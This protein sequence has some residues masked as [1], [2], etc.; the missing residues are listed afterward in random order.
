MS[1]TPW[2]ARAVVPVPAEG[3]TGLSVA[4]DQLSP[5]PPYE[6]IRQQVRAHVTAGLLGTGDRLPTV[7]ALAARLGLA[8]NTVARA[9]Q[10]LEADGLVSTRRRVGTVVTATAAV[11]DDPVAAAVAAG[12]DELARLALRA[13]MAEEDV[14]GLVRGALLRRRSAPLPSPR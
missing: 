1:W 9:Y 3:R 10:E 2:S 11:P 13:G 5:L 7:R 8:T 6:Q 14:V 12:A 4:V